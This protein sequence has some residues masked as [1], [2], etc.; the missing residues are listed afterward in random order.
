MR[1]E[2]YAR[3]MTPAPLLLDSITDIGPQHAGAVVISGSHGGLYPASL[4]SRGNLRAVIFNDA[5]R[6]YEDAGIAGVLALAMLAVPAAAQQQSAPPAA[7]SPGPQG[8]GRPR[9]IL[10]QGQDGGPR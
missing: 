8:P 1:Q 4:A 7:T 2:I 5:G 3:P 10:R 9:G 6:G